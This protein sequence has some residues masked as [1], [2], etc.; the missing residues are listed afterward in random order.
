M[1]GAFFS[2]ELSF[3]VVALVIFFYT[4]VACLVFGIL[5]SFGI[6]RLMKSLTDK[7]RWVR[8]AIFTLS[9][10]VAGF[11]ASILT[12]LIMGLGNP[13]DNPVGMIR[14]GFGVSPFGIAAAIIYG[15]LDRVL[16]RNHV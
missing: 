8:V 14:I 4:M 15:I 12:V 6:D 2:K 13:V 1:L 11:I 10:A 3:Y 9:Y 5:A 7:S 16:W